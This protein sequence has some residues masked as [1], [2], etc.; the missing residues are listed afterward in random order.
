MAS[1][2]H[3]RP[4]SA[5][6]TAGRRETV[7]VVKRNW[8]AEVETAHAYRA[9]AGREPDEKRKG[10]LLR[11]A[12]AEERHAQ[13]WAEKLADLGEPIPT[14][15]DSF[16]RRLQRWLDRALGTEIAIRR[17]EAAEEK[18]EAAFRD[19]RERVLAGEQ[20]VKDFLRESAV[21]EKA[22]ARA[23]D[24]GAATRTSHGAGYHFK[25][26]TLARP[27]WQLGGGRNLW[28]ERRPRRGVWNCFGRRRSDQ[29]PATLYFDFRPR[30]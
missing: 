26:R 22:P 4:A 13:R 2:S 15:P 6:A 28:R 30:W 9:L 12:E 7:E 11:M 24:D 1:D 18:H 27:R 3:D 5:E 17:M 19:Q 16:G 29:Q 25:A 20:D 23:P 14:I 10:I 8:R 21:E